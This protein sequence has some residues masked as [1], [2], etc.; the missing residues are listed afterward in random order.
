MTSAQAAA[1]REERA[2][3]RRAL[4]QVQQVQQVQGAERCWERSLGIFPFL[5]KNKWWCLISFSLSI[6]LG[7]P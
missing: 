2:A 3:Q 6:Q 1:L 5:E 7:I 4:Q